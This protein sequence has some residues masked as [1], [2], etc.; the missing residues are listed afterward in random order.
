MDKNGQCR[1]QKR[2][3]KWTKTDAVEADREGQVWTKMEPGADRG[4]YSRGQIRNPHLSTDACRGKT[5]KTA[6]YDN[7]KPE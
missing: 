7:L 2:I 6:A 1:G 5:A 4:G 3:Q